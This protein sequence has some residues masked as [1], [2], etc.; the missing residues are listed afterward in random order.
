MAFKQ[1]DVDTL[2]AATGRR[3]CVCSRLHRV[4]VHHI[5][6]REQGGTDDIDNGIP[7]CPN[8]HDEVHTGYFPGRTTRTYSAEELRRHRDRTIERMKQQRHWAPGT[9]EY[10]HDKEL[11]L[12]Y[13][14]CLDRPAFRTHFHNELSFSDFDR[15]I[16]DTLLALNTGYWRTRDGV[17]IDRSQGKAHLV[18]QDWRDRLDGI[19]D[20]IEEIRTRFRQSLRLDEMLC[21]WQYPPSYRM[22]R[23]MEDRFRSDQELG[24]WMDEK[25]REAI[26]LMNLILREIDHPELRGLH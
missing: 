6:P 26:E 24:Q 18:S 19:V 17:A 1:S 16:E 2:L 22:D 8:C 21:R 13:A 23:M 14:Q 9:P 10:E 4:Q 25:R 12:F 3:C 7:L 11:V 15:A 20:I 5:I